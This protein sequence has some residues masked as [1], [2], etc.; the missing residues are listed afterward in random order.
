M[1]SPFR[2]HQATPAFHRPCPFFAERTR[3]KRDPVLPLAVEAKRLLDALYALSSIVAA[4]ECI[5]GDDSIGDSIRRH[6]ITIGDAAKLVHSDFERGTSR[7]SKLPQLERAHSKVTHQQKADDRRRAK[8]AEASR[9]KIPSSITRLRE[10]IAKSSGAGTSATS[11]ETAAGSKRRISTRP[12]V[13]SG[14]SVIVVA[15]KRRR[16]TVPAP[17]GN[18][19]GENEI[20]DFLNK[21]SGTGQEFDLAAAAL[22]ATNKLRRSFITKEKGE[23]KLNH[24]IQYYCERSLPKCIDDTRGYGKVEAISYLAKFDGKEKKA[25]IDAMLGT[26]KLPSSSSRVYGDISSFKC[27]VQ[28]REYGETGRMSKA[29]IAAVTEKAK[30]K[31]LNLKAC[32]RDDVQ[33]ITRT[34]SIAALKARGISTMTRQCLYGVKQQWIT[35]VDIALETNL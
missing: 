15:V 34:E 33:E 14:S 24:V 3:K 8:V 9:K 27:G 2:E 29:S 12:A 6:L 32:E 17:C 22:I 35:L 19:Y 26:G 23:L 5:A 21:Y 7:L 20:I 31:S 16:L 10:F 30:Q 11:S 28:L 1:L 25:R 13:T 18:Y 4:V